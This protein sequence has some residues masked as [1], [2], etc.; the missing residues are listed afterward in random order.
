MAD[1]SDPVVTSLIITNVAGLVV[2][3]INL[4]REQRNRNWQVEDRREARESREELHAK[5]DDTQR[6]ITEA[7]DDQ[8]HRI[9]EIGAAI[10][11]HP[12]L[13]TIERKVRDLGQRIPAKPIRFDD[14][15]HILA[16]RHTDDRRHGEQ[17]ERRRAAEQRADAEH[18]G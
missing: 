18:E 9:A 5:L 10:I 13:E 2:Q 1:L 11:D 6:H 4:Y 12:K 17:V 3:A 14:V 7:N 16:Q 15:A 8:T